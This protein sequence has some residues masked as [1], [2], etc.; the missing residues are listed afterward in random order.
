MS[1]I[2]F[3]KELFI[4]TM[5]SQWTE[6]YSKA[7]RWMQVALGI[8]VL[9]GVLKW[10]AYLMT[11]STAIFSDAL[12][13]L[14]NVFAGV[15]GI[16]SIWLSSRPSD[17]RHPYGHGKIEFISAAVEGVL[18]L[19]AGLT[20]M[21]EAVR[22]LY[23]PVQLQ[24]L[25]IG[26]W[27]TAISAVLHFGTGYFLMKKGKLMHS[28]ALESNGRHLRSDS[29]TSFALVLGLVL[30]NLTGWIWMDSLLAIFFGL[31]I[32]K[33]GY[34]IVH[35]SMMGMMDA[36]DDELMEQMV[37]V[38][39]KHRKPEWIDIYNFRTV[40]YGSLLHTDCQLVLPYYISHR[41]ANDWVNLLDETLNRNSRP[42]ELFVHT[43]PCE[44]IHCAHC[45]LQNCR[46]RSFPFESEFSWSR[47][48]LQKKKTSENI[49]KT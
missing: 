1:K 37:K 12:E 6:D 24:H 13:S 9:L 7:L 22:H 33:E 40:K 35:S 31:Y 28:P 26:I 29:F 10:V 34:E 32:L 21:A 2:R 46:F 8:S 14:V 49:S 44:P 27:L 5:P 48:S 39:N 16:Y 42:V 20:I 15:F 23:S 45:S 18:V 17:R 30:V 43:V 41:E 47:E 3:T 36:S 38:L 4:C 25:T 11:D 19:M